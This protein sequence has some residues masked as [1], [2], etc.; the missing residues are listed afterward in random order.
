MGKT[1]TRTEV[2]EKK[3]RRINDKSLRQ[4]L[5]HRFI[6]SYG[7][8]KGEVTAA[9]IVDDILK[10]IDDYFVIALPLRNLP[11]TDFPNERMLSY[12]QLV[13]MAVPIDEETHKRESPLKPRS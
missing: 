2:N 4:L 6:N 11:K 9:A 8:D 7:Y 1:L 3:F 10:T 12:G 13:W 5:I